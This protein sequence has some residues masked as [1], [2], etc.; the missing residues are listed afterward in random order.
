MCIVE[1]SRVVVTKKKQQAPKD[2]IKQKKNEWPCVDIVLSSDTIYNPLSIKPFLETVNGVLR[3]GGRCYIAT[4][5]YY[6]GLGGGV[7]ALK[8]CVRKAFPGL[9]LE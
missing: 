1:A 7:A 5:K 2:P 3:D 8:A 9:S 6:F 4:Q